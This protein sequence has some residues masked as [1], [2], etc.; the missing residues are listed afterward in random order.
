MNDDV[1]V[2]LIEEI[3]AT[4]ICIKSIEDLMLNGGD[5]DSL[6]ATLV[7]ESERLDKL[8]ALLSKLQA[9]T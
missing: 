4:Q 6:M 9:S 2:D 3:E 7:E 5:R 1:I 8:S